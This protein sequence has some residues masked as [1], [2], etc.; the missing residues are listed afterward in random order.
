MKVRS[1]LIGAMAAALLFSFSGIVMADDYVS[2]EFPSNKVIKKNIRMDHTK[3]IGS[4]QTDEEGVFMVYYT[5]PPH[6]IFHT[7]KLIHLDNDS[8]VYVDS[9]TKMKGQLRK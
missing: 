9:P 5:T 8:W 1:I 2:K 3:I 6:K 4:K 7:F